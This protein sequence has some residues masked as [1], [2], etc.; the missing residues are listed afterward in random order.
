M[1]IKYILDLTVD[2]S[3]LLGFFE[4]VTTPEQLVSR[5]ERLKRNTTEEMLACIEGLRTSLG[6]LLEDTVEPS[7]NLDDDDEGDDVKDLL[8]TLDEPDNTATETP[9]ETP[10]ETTPSKDAP[11]NDLPAVSQPPT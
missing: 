1:K 7:G 11:P 9:A 10:A 5:L 6:S 2:A 4:D 3:D 8:S